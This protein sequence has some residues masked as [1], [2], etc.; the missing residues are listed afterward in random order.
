MIDTYEKEVQFFDDAVEHMK[1]VFRAKRI[2]YGPT[3]TETY[4]R[5]GIASM[6]TRMYDKIGRLENLTVHRGGDSPAVRDE[7]IDDTLLDL[8]NYA[9]ITILERAKVNEEYCESKA[10]RSIGESAHDM[11][12]SRVPVCKR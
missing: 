10:D 6:L 2:D 4:A 7:S 11:Y 1:K 8:A 5:F 9:I 3:T 12:E